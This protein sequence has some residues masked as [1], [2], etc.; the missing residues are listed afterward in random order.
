M[1]NLIFCQGS[2]NHVGADNAI[3]VTL[4]KKTKQAYSPLAKGCFARGESHILD[5]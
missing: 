3:Y 2:L 4:C 5:W 1:L